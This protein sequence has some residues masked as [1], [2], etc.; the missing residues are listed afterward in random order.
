MDKQFMELTFI[1]EYSRKRSKLIISVDSIMYF[2]ETDYEQTVLLLVREGVKEKITVGESY[3][4]VQ[5]R[6][7]V[8]RQVQNLKGTSC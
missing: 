5:Q 2:Y 4:D 6:L 8:A 3:S 7:L 1:E